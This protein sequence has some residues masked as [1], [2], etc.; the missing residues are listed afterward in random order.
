[1]SPSSLWR[2]FTAE[3]KIKVFL[4]GAITGAF[5]FGYFLL[6]RLPAVP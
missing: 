1:M 4:G 5:W 3:W 6:E 2:R